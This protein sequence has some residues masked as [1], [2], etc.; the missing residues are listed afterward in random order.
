MDS[1]RRKA[2]LLAAAPLVLV[3]AGQAWAEIKKPVTKLPSGGGTGGRP[4]KFVK[5]AGIEAAVKARATGIYLAAS[6][7]VEGSKRYD[8]L[9]LINQGAAIEVHTK[10][11]GGGYLAKRPG[12]QSVR[13]IS[14]SKFDQLI[15]AAGGLNRNVE[16]TQA[17]AGFLQLAGLSAG[18]STGGGSTGGGSTGGTGGTSVPPCPSD[19]A[20]KSIIQRKKIENDPV[21][22]QQYLGCLTELEPQYQE[23]RTM[24]T[25]LWDALPPLVPEAHAEAELVFFSISFDNLFKSWGFE[26]NPQAGYT[27]FNAFGVAAIWSL[28]GGSGGGSGG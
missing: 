6:L 10:Q 23:R 26:Y 9:T 5:P 16:G 24:L 17:K 18:G 20:S 28:S 27:T 22:R 21:M 15:A 13:V 14:T 4:G 2:V 19:W 7:N 11:S 3:G 8:T 1:T 12:A 25:R